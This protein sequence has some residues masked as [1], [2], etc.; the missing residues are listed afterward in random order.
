LNKRRPAWGAF[1]LA[2]LAILV[3]AARELTWIDAYTLWRSRGSFV[4]YPIPFQATQL[5]MD[6]GVADVNGDD[7]LDIFTSNHNYRQDLLVADG[8]GGYR[9][10]LSVWKLDQ[11]T[12]F[13]G[14]EI[15]LKQPKI[16]APGLYMYWKSRRILAVRSH[17]IK[18]LGQAHVKLVSY[19]TFNKYEGNGFAVERPVM[20]GGDDRKLVQ[21]AIGITT[22]TDGELDIE[23]ETPGTPI[24]VE[25]DGVMPLSSVYVGVQN[26]SP[27]SS[28]FELTFQDRH[29]LAWADYNDDGLMDVFITRGAL[30]GQARLLPESIE[31]GIQDEL[32]VSQ[33]PGRYRSIAR[34][35]GIE[36]HDCSGRKVNWV[37][38]DRTGLLDL[39]INCQ[40]RDNAKNSGTYPKQLWR[41]TPDKRFVDVAAQVG[42]DIPDHEIIDFVWFDAD[43]DGYIDLLTY[44]DTGFYLYRN[45]GGKSFKREFIG[46]GK[47]A[48]AD[49][50]KLRG[51]VEEYWFADG[52]LTVGD[53]RGKGEFDVFSAS[54]T[55]NTL[56]LNDG[57]GHFKIV[58]PKTLGLPG[59]SVTA[60]WVDFDN[61]GRLDLYCMPQGLFRQRPDHTFEAT[62]L[63]R[64]P[65]HKYMA[66]IANWADLTNDGRRDLVLASLQN[67]SQWRWWE[68]LIHRDSED[69]FSWSINAYRNMVAQDNHW[70]ELRLA[71]K[72]GNP[73][74]IGAR[75]TLQNADGLQTQQ[76]GL[77]DGAFFSQGH[78]RLYFGLGSHTKA[79]LLT[80]RWPDGEVQEL[81]SVAGDRLLVVEQGKAVQ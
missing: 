81:R 21:S 12:E 2:V 52:K 77:N 11:S 24:A 10:M 29:G 67:F 46:R 3:V 68:R 5:L 39:Y 6:I 51:I 22:Q 70:L 14:L 55:G 44:E 17:L 54:K 56:L 43:N 41:Q 45:Q 47:F 61:D 35:V 32:I 71:G 8:K 20:T 64:L 80:V 15:A 38:F 13:P 23:V 59:E 72:R 1:G 9:D 66:A 63:L 58:D 76:V 27:R 25:I 18:D 34:D 26:V 57:Q 73:Q 7:W 62:G 4:V 79:D 48:R 40:D 42:L 78:Y 75:V 53:F 16:A 36:K 31:R 19:T 74:G 60:G 33:G 65:E 50:P 69:R 37:D 30:S 49:N 28:R